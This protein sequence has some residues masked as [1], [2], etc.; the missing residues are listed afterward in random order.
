VNILLYTANYAPEPTGIGKYSGEMTAWLAAQGHAVRVVCAVPYYPAWRV[1]PGYRWPP[2]RRET[3]AGVSVWRAPLWVP[4]RPGG[5]S[6][7]LHLLSF[8]LSSLPLMVRQVFWRPDVVMTVAPAFVCAPA[9]WLCARLCGA[10][11]WLHVQDF[12]IDVAFRMGLLKGQ[13]TKRAVL[14]AEC[15]MLRRFDRVSSISQRMHARLLEKGVAASRARMLPNWVDI[16]RVRPLQQPSAYRAELGISPSAV[17]ALFSG[18]LGPKQALMQIPAAARLLQ[19]RRPDVVFVVCGDGVMKP[20]LEAAAAGLGNLRL[21]PLQP[22]ERLAELLGLADIH[23]LTQSSD[24][25]DLVLPS[26]LSGMLASGR[27]VV[28]TCR[29][30][31]EIASVIEACGLVVA[32]E[33]AVALA[34]AIEALAADPTRRAALGRQARVVAETS[35]SA[36]SVLAMLVL[37]LEQTLA[38]PQV[39]PAQ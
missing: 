6:R 36:R 19:A 22:V 4:A 18:T 17:V 25:E 24:A 26:K 35:M 8:A 21:L 7:V 1:W 39:E 37:D 3:I 12:E 30:L 32:P 9:G 33:D 38:E 34:D 10:A 11:A 29:P 28:A 15:W 14:A 5:L 27:P 2:Y 23:L 31:T 20:A 13:R 16:D